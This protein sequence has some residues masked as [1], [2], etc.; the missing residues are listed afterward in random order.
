[1]MK[2]MPALLAALAMTATA[3][4]Q[5][6]DDPDAADAA[7]A[8]RHYSVEVIIFRY[9]ED[10][11]VGTE[12]FVPER[13]LLQP[14]DEILQ[15]PE[16]RDE[17]ATPV[18]PFSMRLL[19]RDELTLG[20]AYGRLDR[21]DAY[22]PLMHFGWEQP[23]I[24]AEQTPAL[25]LSRFSRVPAGLDGTLTLYL[26]RYLHLVVDV[27]L[28]A[29]PDEA[30]GASPYEDYDEV[31][32]AEYGDQ[33]V[34]ATDYDDVYLPLR[35]RIVE[36]RILKNGETRYYDHPKFGVIAKVLRIEDDEQE[37]R[38]EEGPPSVAR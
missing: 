29:P 18:H 38:G 20:E 36:D 35:Y 11:S 16:T 5:D 22:E 28:A 27:S 19:S 31:A 33:R 1:M 7:E 9:L 23:T 15:A 2:R 26:N 14:V 24:P 30:S 10:V 25:P 8:P 3:I 37:S 4:A 17:E 21:L 6:A 13:A 12:I 34:A 32:V